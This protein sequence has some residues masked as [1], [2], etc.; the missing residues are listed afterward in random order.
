[1]AEERIPAQGDM[2]K[3]SEAGYFGIVHFVELAHAEY[4]L[5][6]QRMER[7]QVGCV[8]LSHGPHHRCIVYFGHYEEH[9]GTAVQV[10][11]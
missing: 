6:A 9:I 11:F 3:D 2:G 10:N 4:S 7:L 5:L 8:R 1:M